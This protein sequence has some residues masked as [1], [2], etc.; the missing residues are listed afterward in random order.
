VSRRRYLFT[1]DIRDP[2]RLRR[3][4]K[5]AKTYGWAMQYSVFVC[6]LDAMELVS[7]QAAIGEVIHHRVDSVAIID[8]G[9]PQE[10]GRTSFSFMGIAPELP[11]SG[12]VVI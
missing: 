2:A 8:L 3:V 10:R 1:Y 11:T 12:S 4:H 9:H 6:D 7:L 5:V